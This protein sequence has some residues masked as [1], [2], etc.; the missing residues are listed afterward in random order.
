MPS[1]HLN[2]PV[3]ELR[4]T[5][6]PYASFCSRQPDACDLSGP[7]MIEYSPEVMRLLK[8]ENAVANDEIDCNTTD[9][10]LYNVE[11]YWAIPSGGLGDCED[12][13]L[14]KRELLVRRGLPRGAITIAIVHHKRNLSSHV[15]LLVETT[16]GTYL[17]NSLTNEIVLWHRAPY[18]FESR[19][20]PDGTWV[21]YD[22]ELWT[23]E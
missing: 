15:A 1:R 11:E 7:S 10:E 6:R 17:L 16:D 18:N 5:Y 20:R 4:E 22:Q 13:A 2:L 14:Y 3:V 12:V 8:G 23:Y 9:E 21:R 19:E